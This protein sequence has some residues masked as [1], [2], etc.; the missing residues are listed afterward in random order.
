METGI[1]VQH[2]T[3]QPLT[4]REMDL[5]AAIW[6]AANIEREFYFVSTGAR[7]VLLDRALLCPVCRRADHWLIIRDGAI[8]C[9][10]C[11]AEYQDALVEAKLAEARGRLA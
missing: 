7:H 4:G 8:R 2:S 1:N 6:M 9:Q 5:L 11:D 3:L 10:P